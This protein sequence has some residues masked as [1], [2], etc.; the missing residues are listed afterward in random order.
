M[1][2]I[3]RVLIAYDGSK[4][5]DQAIRDL[6]YA[7]MPKSLDAVVL[8]ASDFALPPAVAAFGISGLSSKQIDDLTLESV[9]QARIT[10]KRAVH[11]LKDSFPGWRIKSEA[12]SGSP[13]KLLIDKARRWKTDLIVMGAQGHSKIGRFLGSISQLVL[14]QAPCSVRIGRTPSEKTRKGL[15]I[16]VAFDGSSGAE[17]AAQ[18]VRCRL[19]PPETQFQIAY[20]LNRAS[21]GVL[22]P[23]RYRAAASE[24]MKAHVSPLVN[25]LSNVEFRTYEGD[26]KQ[27]L[28]NEAE[29][30][31][32]DCVFVGARNLTG[33][34]RLLLG[35][36]SMAIAARASCSVEVVRPKS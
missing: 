31:N 18:S 23:Q 17:E 36:V 26:P 25:R 33:A 22:R 8:T 3:N 7:G 14:M 5:S 35:G 9:K 6:K 12:G 34:R 28:V 4:S 1:R 16:L 13:T 29:R 10:A 20:V 15:R 27:V 2:K 32:A 21:I 11:F 19:W 24:M 30:W